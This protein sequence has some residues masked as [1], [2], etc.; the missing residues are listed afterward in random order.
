MNAPTNSKP[1]LALLAAPPSAVPGPR[2]ATL[3]ALSRVAGLI[4]AATL[5]ACSSAPPLPKLVFTPPPAR[6]ATAITATPQVNPDARKRPSPV[7]VRVYELKADTAFNNADFMSLYQGDSATL[8]AD[9]VYREEFMLQ[10]GET[11]KLDR[12]LDEKSRFVAVV[13]AYR[14]IEKA[15]WRAITPLAA[16][17]SQQAK[18]T[19]D[20]L[21]VSVDVTPDKR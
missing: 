6:L 9:I 18:V 17:S 14:D 16:G 21:T 2:H 20:A 19:V 8:A 11:R 1:H 5:V 3:S 7:L 15:R 4:A 10:P 13:A 12:L